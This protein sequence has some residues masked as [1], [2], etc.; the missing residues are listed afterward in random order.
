MA[1]SAWRGFSENRAFAARGQQ[2][3]VDPIERYTTRTETTTQLGVKVNEQSRN[4]AE[5]FFRDGT[6]RRVRISRVLPD[7]VL[8]KFTAG[9]P[10]YVEYLPE[11]PETARLAGTSARP[12]LGAAVAVVAAALTALLWRRI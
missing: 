4:S 11:A 6:G 2:A 5:L 10:V 12:S 1:F 3:V 7:E 8:A 9:T